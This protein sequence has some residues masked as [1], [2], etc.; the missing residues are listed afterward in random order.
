MLKI[1]SFCNKFMIVT[2]TQKAKSK[3]FDFYDF[4]NTASVLYILKLY[5]NMY[6]NIQSESQHLYRFSFDIYF[7]LVLINIHTMNSYGICWTHPTCIPL[8]QYNFPHSPNIL[9]PGSIS[10][11][12]SRSWKQHILKYRY[13]KS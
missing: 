3:D 2:Y 5:I 7:V 11:F 4:K 1:F 8:D 10:N 9:A 6:E 13:L 12:L